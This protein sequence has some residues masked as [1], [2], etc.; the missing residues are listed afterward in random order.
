MRT[1]LASMLRAAPVRDAF[2]P[3]TISP[4]CQ[5]DSPESIETSMKLSLPTAL[6]VTLASMLISTG[7]AAAANEAPSPPIHC[8]ENHGEWCLLEGARLKS[9]SEADRAVVLELGPYAPSV[10]QDSMILVVPR[11]CNDGL[12]DRLKLVSMKLD[13]AYRGSTK[14]EIK[15]ELSSTCTLTALLPRWTD[16]PNEW[17]YSGGLGSIRRCTNT[18]CEGETLA[19]L[20]R[21]L[22]TRYQRRAIRL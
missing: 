15:V 3:I 19:D 5:D 9:V 21:P 7:H 22:A 18:T 2:R 11:G 14:D 8:V 13:Q 16:A 10:S 1:H 6:L 12:S 4:C 17:P 20:V